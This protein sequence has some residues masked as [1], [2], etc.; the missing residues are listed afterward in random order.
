MNMRYDIKRV[1]LLAVLFLTI[2]TLANATAMANNNA[3]NA[4]AMADNPAKATSDNTT[5]ATANNHVRAAD[6]DP[7]VVDV[8]SDI[9]YVITDADGNYLANVDGA[10]TKVTATCFPKVNLPLSSPLLRNLTK[11]VWV[12]VGLSLNP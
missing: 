12:R 7:T 3:A 10:I 11:I 4:T 8:T 2:G 9:L 1:A 6:S 5:S